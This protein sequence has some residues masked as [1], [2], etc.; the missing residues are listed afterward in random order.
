M[1]ALFAWWQGLQARERVLLAIGATAAV[2]TL[3]F[4]LVVEPMAEREERLKKALAVEI[5]TRSWL[6]AQRPAA[7]GAGTRPSERLPDGASLLATINQSAAE[8]AVAAQLKR[9]TPAAARS[10]NLG[11]E[12]VP[13]ANFMRWLIGL[14][15]R[16]GAGVQRIR[17]E[18]S[19][20][21]GMV[22][23]ELSLQF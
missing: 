1:S 13:Y 8:S 10:V 16:Y 22:N 6:E 9:I 14:E 15:Q 11:F 20:S 12:S 7:G 17:M 23:V 2:S 4:L 3:Y 18:S 19:G 21:A 5:E